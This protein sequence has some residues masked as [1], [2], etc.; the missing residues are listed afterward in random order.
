MPSGRGQIRPHSP[1]RPSSTVF[2]P[3]LCV[4]TELSAIPR[5]GDGD[6]I[7]CVTIPHRLLSSTPSTPLQN[8]IHRTTLSATPSYDNDYIRLHGT[9][10]S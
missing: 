7:H 6:T 1:R 8:S 3:L 5:A 2:K 4:C 10:P 9:T